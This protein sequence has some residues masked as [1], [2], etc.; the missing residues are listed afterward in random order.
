MIK[1]SNTIGQNIKTLR[2]VLNKSQKDFAKET[3]ISTPTLS[4][5]ENN[6]TLPSLDFLLY[7]KNK[8]NISIDTFTSELLSADEIQ[9]EMAAVPSFFIP[10]N[11]KKYLGT[12]ILYYYTTSTQDSKNCII[13]AQALRMGLLTLYSKSSNIVDALACFNLDSTMLEN[14]YNSIT[15]SNN[16]YK[17]T[18]EIQLIH[19]TYAQTSKTNYYK[20]N[21]TFSPDNIF[22]SLNHNYRDC[23]L[24]ILKNPNSEQS[25]YIG[26]I[27]TM[28]SVS[29]GFNL[30]PCI[31]CVALSR[32]PL[33][34]SLDEIAR[35]LQFNHI[36]LNMYNETLELINAFKNL[37]TKASLTSVPFSDEQKTYLIQSL[38]EKFVDETVTSNLFRI[39]KVSSDKDDDWYHLI[40]R[41]SKKG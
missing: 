18:Q 15:Q 5:Y 4:S 20:G 16:I 24:I 7:L 29:K 34:I 31:Q 1:N 23:S 36:N 37:Y 9:Q 38:L 11:I 27:G 21:V 28:N 14:I 33:T 30:D 19:K 41:Y 25:T 13:P 3:N 17:G 10:S 22:I 40:K 8:Y 12:Y 2:D 39:K 32:Y 35:E 6:A 26:G